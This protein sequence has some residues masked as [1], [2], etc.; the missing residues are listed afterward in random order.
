[1]HTTEAGC[2][3]G[4]HL[5]GPYG[6]P[7]GFCVSNAHCTGVLHDDPFAVSQ[8]EAGNGKMIATVYAYGNTY[9]VSF[10]STATYLDRPVYDLILRPRFDPKRYQLR[11]ML[12]T[13]ATTV[14]IR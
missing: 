1:M 10:G 13:Q 12:W 4:A 6:S 3:P 9:D 7:L 11:E 8:P 14:F 5:T 2:A